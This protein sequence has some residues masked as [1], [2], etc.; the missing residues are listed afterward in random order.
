MKKSNRSKPNKANVLNSVFG[1]LLLSLPTIPLIAVAQPSQVLNPCP[2]IYYEEPFKSR[3]LVP[4]GCPP[5]AA[6][7]RLR[8]TTDPLT[9][10][11]QPSDP[12][13][14]Q[15]TP[16]LPRANPTPNAIVPTDAPTTPGRV[17]PTPSQQR[18]QRFSMETNHEI[19]TANNLPPSFNIFIASKTIICPA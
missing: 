1:S 8:G 19:S 4:E 2:K 14:G 16:G 5:S 3:N 12:V 11:Q 13:A 10:N 15:R 7:H 9:V 17:V 18:T 6:T